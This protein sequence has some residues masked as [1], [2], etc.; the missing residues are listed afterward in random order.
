MAQEG[1][2]QAIAANETITINADGTVDK[3][4]VE[5]DNRAIVEFKSG[6]GRGWEI[7]FDDGDGGYYPI[8]LLE[9]GFASAYLV[10]DSINGA[11]TCPYTVR[12]LMAPEPPEKTNRVMVNYQIIIGDG[13]EGKS[14]RRK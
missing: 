9:G 1:Q 4:S 12:S 3:P 7:A 11:D 13:G 2:A 8:T 10:A 5:V 14:K 6:T